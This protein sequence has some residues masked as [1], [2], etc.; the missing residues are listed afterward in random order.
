MIKS[1]CENIQNLIPLYIDNMLSENE[2]DILLEHIANCKACKEE[3]I[4]M[5][6]M[7][8]KIAELPEIPVSPTFHRKLMERVRKEKVG[9]YTRY[10][11]GWKSAASFVAAAAV[12]ALSVVSF[13]SLDKDGG[14]QNPDVYLAT[15][16]PNVML[17]QSEQGENTVDDIVQES[18]NPTEKST[19]PA[20]QETVTAKEERKQ[21][22]QAEPKQAAKTEMPVSQEIVS[23]TENAHAPAVARVID[24]QNAAE[25]IPETATDNLADAQGAETWSLSRDAD[26]A[27]PKTVPES[28]ENSAKVSGGGS[29]GGG[30][31]AASGGSSAVKRFS[32][33]SVTV[34]ESAMAQAKEILSAF[35]KDANGYK[36]GASLD[37]VLASLSTL[38]GYSVSVK[39]GTDISGNYIVLY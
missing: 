28:T 38:D 36:V 4:L 10:T 31:G 35:A 12:V 23:D 3:L 22:A 5:Q 37:D 21:Q 20:A 33:A 29:S 1:D 6:T 17:E 16:S 34:A 9:G 8:S 7:V 13:L 11:R 25:S 14:N 19:A 32:I 39:K 27:E 26:K 18:V 30:G 2:R 15:P 24:E